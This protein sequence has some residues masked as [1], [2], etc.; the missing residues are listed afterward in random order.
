MTR[1]TD[2]AHQVQHCGDGCC[3]ERRCCSKALPDVSLTA[4]YA[5]REEQAQRVSSFKIGILWGA[6][7]GRHINKCMLRQDA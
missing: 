2:A 3:R 6:G 4:I 7:S 5:S 1:T